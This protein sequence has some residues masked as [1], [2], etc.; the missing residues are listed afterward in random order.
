MARPRPVGQRAPE[1]GRSEAAF[2]AAEEDAALAGAEVEPREAPLASVSRLPAREAAERVRQLDA[3]NAA[4][5]LDD[6]PWGEP[7][8]AD[9]SAEHGVA[10]TP[11]LGWAVAD[12]VRSAFGLARAVA[13][14]P[15]RL[16]VAVPRL[17]LRAVKRT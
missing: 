5:A 8:S 1:S 17:A 15:I 2:R 9:V 11:S 10:A 12:L 3:E 6:P 4:G 16:A 7:P 13:G 14:A